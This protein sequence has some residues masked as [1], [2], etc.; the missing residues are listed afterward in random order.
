MI[1]CQLDKND[2]VEKIKRIN[3]PLTIIAIFAAL[4]EIN[5]TIAIGLI[6]KDLHQIFIWFVIGF[7]TLLVVLF[8]LT[9]NYNTKVMYSPSDYHDDKSFI[10]LLGGYYGDKKDKGDEIDP[11]KLSTDIESKI[12]EKL[13]GKLDEILKKSKNPELQKEIEELKNQIKT[14]SD[15]SIVEFKEMYSI[16]TDLKEILLSLYRFP[17]FYMLIYAIVRTKATSTDNLNSTVRKYFLPGDWE[18]S[19]LP[20]LFE[21]G[22]LVGENSNFKLNPIYEEGLV[23]WV[24]FNNM[25]LRFMNNSFKNEE[26]QDEEKK[27]KAKE[28]II[29]LTER[30]RF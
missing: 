29:E 23:K 9:L 16:P 5:A 25:K 17:A 24:E 7:P 30:L 19:G 27:Q 26:S 22:I 15:Q 18:M 8:F 1:Y 28:R 6:D 2:M 20:Q 3:N 11:L 4:A 14:V 21:K 10:D 12:T 13:E